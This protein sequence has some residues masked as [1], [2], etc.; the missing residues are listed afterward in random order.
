MDDTKPDIEPEDSGITEFTYF[1]PLLMITFSFFISLS[2]LWP[3]SMQQ[4]YA[5]ITKPFYHYLLLSLSC[6]T[7]ILMMFIKE[8]TLILDRKFKWEDGFM[9]RLYL[10]LVFGGMV[11]VVLLVPIYY[12]YLYLE[13]DL[14]NFLHLGHI[15]FVVTMLNMMYGFYYYVKLVHVGIET[16]KEGKL[17]DHYRDY[18]IVPVGMGNI[19]FNLN[20][21][22]FFHRDARDV[23]LTTF[24]GK[25]YPLWQSLDEIEKELNP[26]YFFRVNRRHIVNRN[27]VV[28]AD[29]NKRKGMDVY[30]T[31]A[32]ANPDHDPKCIDL[33]REKVKAFKSW[34][35]EDELIFEAAS[36]S[37]VY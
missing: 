30:I 15:P 14:G 31:H 25:K 12:M 13:V 33:S 26:R 4:F 18:F 2:M 35:K 16:A 11:A 24:E 8:V 37:S 10:Q 23:C 28:N 32:S 29:K 19:K 5:M 21:I 3:N 36:D 1:S 7:C 6:F 20:E 22:A 34:L 9:N 17:D 27:A